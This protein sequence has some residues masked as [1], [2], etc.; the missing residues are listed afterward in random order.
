MQCKKTK[1]DKLP[2][3]CFYIFLPRNNS[4]NNIWRNP[5]I[6]K[7]VGIF[8]L[9]FIYGNTKSEWRFL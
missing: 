8:K 6:L 4:K 2:C 1:K 5:K 3:Y 9:N 7:R